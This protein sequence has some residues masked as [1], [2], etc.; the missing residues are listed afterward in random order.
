MKNMYE[1]ISFPAPTYKR[2]NAI[3]F[4]NIDLVVSSTTIFS[5]LS[6]P[7]LNV[8][9]FML[10]DLFCLNWIPASFNCIADRTISSSSR[11][12]SL[13][14]NRFKWFMMDKELI[15]FPSCLSYVTNIAYVDPCARVR[16][17]FMLVFVSCLV[18]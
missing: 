10:P 17:V 13:I 12:S 1:V 15:Y 6:V 11:P 8:M 5:N 18:E 16:V 7:R 3:R 14:S 9:S 4:R 2:S